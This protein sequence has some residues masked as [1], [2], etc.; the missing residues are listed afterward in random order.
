[1]RS[2]PRHTFLKTR[3][4]LIILAF[5]VSLCLSSIEVSRT[6]VSTTDVSD[7][8]GMEWLHCEGKFFVNE[9]GKTVTLQG[10]NF[11]GVDY[12]AARLA[13]AGYTKPDDVYQ[14]EDFARAKSLGFNAIRLL[15]SWQLIEPQPGVYDEGYLSLI[16]KL[17]SWAEKYG[18]YVILEMMQHD[19]SSHFFSDGWGLPEWMVSAYSPDYSGFEKSVIDFWL[20]KAP[21]GTSATTDNPSMQDRYIMMWKTVAKRYADE[22]N[23]LFSLMNEP[24]VVN[25]GTGA[26]IDGYTMA[27]LVDSAYT[28]YGKVISG[29]RTVD[30]GHILVIEGPFTVWSNTQNRRIS[31]EVPQMHQPNIALDDHFYG[32]H[33]GYDGNAANLRN[34]FE[35]FWYDPIKIDIPIIIGEWGTNILDS[36]ATN[37]DKYLQDTMRIFTD[38]RLSQTWYIYGPFK[39]T[40]PLCT[41]QWTKLVTGNM[42]R[43]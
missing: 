40:N 13:K 28:F 14:E 22:P 6:A 5:L 33:F 32:S 3:I 30:M 37:A 41:P 26:D 39:P 4:L 19:W 42:L 23:L 16:D 35:T 12:N 43:P 8:S 31:Y 9:N 24:P 27:Q 11:E 38:Y 25:Y 2:C 34:Y 36:R 20:G 7:P 17:V 29:I 21:N 15:V 10:V 1:M 18:L